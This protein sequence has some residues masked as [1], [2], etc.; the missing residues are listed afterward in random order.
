MMGPPP[1]AKKE[2]VPPR[3]LTPP[4]TIPP[5]FAA[6]KPTGPKMNSEMGPPPVPPRRWAEEGQKLKEEMN[7]AAKEASAKLAAQEP[8]A[9]MSAAEP[10]KRGSR[11]N[12]PSQVSREAGRS[13]ERMAEKLSDVK[14]ELA[15]MTA[16]LETTC[17]ENAEL[18]GKMAEMETDHGH[19]IKL[20][21]DQISQLEA[22]NFQV[23]TAHNQLLASLPNLGQSGQYKQLYEQAEA[24]RAELQRRLE[25]NTADNLQQMK[26]MLEEKQAAAE[27]R[28]AQLVKEHVRQL[29][30]K[31]KEIRE[32]S[33]E[34]TALREE[35]LQKASQAKEPRKKVDPK[36]PKAAAPAKVVPA[37]TKAAPM[38]MEEAI[39]KDVTLEELVR[40]S[41]RIEI[42]TTIICH[43]LQARKSGAGSSKARNNDWY[44]CS[45]FNTAESAQDRPSKPSAGPGPKRRKMEQAPKSDVPVVVRF[46]SICLEDRAR[47]PSAAPSMVP[48]DV[49]LATLTAGSF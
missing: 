19:K 37:K 48:T 29:T 20:L 14:V 38:P 34:A 11:P 47:S 31:E 41:I 32:Q 43:I 45:A 13:W 8:K 12:R 24:G 35:L 25:K 33:R 17:T 3:A 5:R 2:G 44:P 16:A 6:A 21:Q 40:A 22:A 18:K 15:T 23:T 9:M 30:D 10:V 39:E 4:K 49:R 27:E 7:A 1:P 26:V 46:T 36:Q 42:S 28:R